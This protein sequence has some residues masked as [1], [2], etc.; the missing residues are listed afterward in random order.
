M[1]QRLPIRLT[2]EQRNGP[3]SYAYMSEKRLVG[4]QDHFI[5]DV[6]DLVSA[7]WTD[8]EIADPDFSF[9]VETVVEADELANPGIITY[10]DL[11]WNDFKETGKQM[12]WAVGRQA[13]DDTIS[14]KTYKEPV[15]AE[16]P[17]A[18]PPLQKPAPSPAPKRRGR[19]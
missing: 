10:C 8:A 11:D 6:Q 1:D 2:A 5:A 4:K 14:L 7:A 13:A 15:P 9:S 16:A 3:G 12:G 17:P 18:E 19:K